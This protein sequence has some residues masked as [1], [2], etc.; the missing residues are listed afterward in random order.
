MAG[1]V[2]AM[3]LGASNAKAATGRIVFSGAVV[4]PSCSASTADL[5]VAA[6]ARVGDTAPHRYTCGAPGKPANMNRVYSM[7][8]VSLDAGASAHDRLLKYYAGY[9]GASAVDGAAVKLVVQ[10]YE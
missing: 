1:C 2:L 3:I 10:T 5:D 9:I 4:E 6:S 8:I 7:A